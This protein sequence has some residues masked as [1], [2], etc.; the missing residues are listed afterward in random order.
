MTI[1]L[2]WPIEIVLKLVF[3]HPYSVLLYWPS[4]ATVY[5]E[6]VFPVKFQMTHLLAMT[7]LCL[8]LDKEMFLLFDILRLLQRQKCSL[9]HRF[10]IKNLTWK[11]DKNCIDPENHNIVVFHTHYALFS[12]SCKLNQFCQLQGCNFSQTFPESDL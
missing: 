3:N 10:I 8:M 4:V 5:T 12:I 11:F 1:H 2:F 6:I 9:L 7:Y